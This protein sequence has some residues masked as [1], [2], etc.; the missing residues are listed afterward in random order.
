M[1][2]RLTFVVLSSYGVFVVKNDIFSVD[3]DEVKPD[4]GDLF[5]QLTALFSAT[6]Q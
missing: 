3:L 5:A 1:C 6:D 2:S 4:S